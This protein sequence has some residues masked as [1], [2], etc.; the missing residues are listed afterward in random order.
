VQKLAAKNQGKDP[1]TER[2][3]DSLKPGMEDLKKKLEE[4][5][6]PV[7]DENAV[8]YA[9]FPQELT[10]LYQAPKEKAPAAASSPPKPA[11]AA[12]PAAASAPATPTA[13]ADGKTV[14][15]LTI[16]GRTYEVQ[17]EEL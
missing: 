1:I 11:T 9:M 13:N 16:E 12:A 2:P 14:L 8:L 3:A 15:G 4:K 6:L 7:S 5:G 17:V 10:K